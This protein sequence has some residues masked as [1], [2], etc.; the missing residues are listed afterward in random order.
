MYCERDSPQKCRLRRGDAEEI[1]VGMLRNL[2]PRRICTFE[3]SP[4]E[5]E[6]ACARGSRTSDLILMT[7][8]A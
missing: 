7:D 1:L 8:F 5:K 3:I 6:I 4:D 2:L